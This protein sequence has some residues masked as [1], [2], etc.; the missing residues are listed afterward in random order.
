MGALRRAVWGG[1][2]FQCDLPK[3]NRY[4]APR[5]SGGVIGMRILS[6]SRPISAFLFAGAAPAKMAWSAMTIPFN[7]GWD[8][9]IFLGRFGAAAPWIWYALLSVATVLNLPVLIFRSRYVAIV[10]DYL[11]VAGFRPIK[12]QEIVQTEIGRGAMQRPTLRII[13]DNRRIPISSLM[14]ATNLLNLQAEIDSE[15]DRR[16]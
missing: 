10:D 6:K 3:I 13:A 8:H 1:R 9:T 5:F 7:H 15:R 12:L 2:T 11:K 16:R 14:A 4:T